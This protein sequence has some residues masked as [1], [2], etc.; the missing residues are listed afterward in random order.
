MRVNV[1]RQRI[2]AVWAVVAISMA[3][4]TVRGE[5]AKSELLLA[6]QTK[7]IYWQ[8]NLKG[9]V[10]L[11]VR[12]KGGEGCAYFFWRYWPFGQTLSLG[13]KCGRFSAEFKQTWTAAGGTLWGRASNGDVQVV[14]SSVEEVALKFPKVEFP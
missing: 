10:F 7:A 4:S 8:I 9:R 3:C 14:G 6:G 5:D 1:R 12:A 2:C 13:E 11:D